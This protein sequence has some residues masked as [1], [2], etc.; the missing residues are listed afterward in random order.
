[1]SEITVRPAT[2]ADAEFLV[3]GNASMALE[4]EALSLDL[5]RLRDGVHALFEK[6]DR[7]VYYVAEIAGRGAGQLMLTYEWSD[8]RNGDFWWIQSVWVEKEFRGQGV[9]TAM[10]RFVENLARTTPDVAGLRLYVEHENR[11]AQATYHRVGMA[12]TVYEMFEVDFV[13]QRTESL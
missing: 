12:R 8:W 13:L 9:F 5:D 7:G 3:R 10:Y 6:P 2:A 4:T 1:M 11:R